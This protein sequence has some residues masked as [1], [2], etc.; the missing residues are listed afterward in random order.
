M[1]LVPSRRVF[2]FV[3]AFALLQLPAT[4][5]LQIALGPQPTKEVERIRAEPILSRRHLL[6]YRRI[7]GN[8]SLQ[9]AMEAHCRCIA[10]F[11]PGPRDV[12]L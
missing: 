2:L 4:P 1:P 12:G 6:R 10:Q 9:A 7:P 5:L 3:C 8:R 11:L